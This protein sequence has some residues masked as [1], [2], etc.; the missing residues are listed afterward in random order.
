MSAAFAAAALLALLSNGVP[1]AAITTAPIN[2]VIYDPPRAIDPTTTLL[3]TVAFAAPRDSTPAR[4]LAEW[5]RFVAP[6][7]EEE[8]YL[9]HLQV[10]GL[11][12]RYPW[13]LRGFSGQESRRLAARIGTHPWSGRSTFTRRPRFIAPRPFSIAFW[14]NTAFPYGSNDGPVWAGRGATGSIEAGIHASAGPLSVVVAP[15]AF[16]AQN[17]SFTLLD[18]GLSGNQA[19]ADGQFGTA[20]DRPQRFGDGAY[21]RLDPGNSTL[22]VDVGPLAAG[23]S[24]ANMV[25]GPFDR[26]PFILGTNAPGFAH[27]F[28]GTA[29][30]LPLW[31]ARIHGRVVWGRLEQSAYSPVEGEPTYF[32]VSESGTRRFASGLVA[33]LEPRG[34]SGL[35]LGVARF[36]HSPWPRSGIPSTYFRKPFTGF[37]KRALPGTPGFPDLQGGGDNQLAS[38][39]ARWLIP[40]A[41]LEVYAEYGREDHSFDKRDFLQ[42]PDH[43]RAYGLGVRRVVLARPS[44]LDGVG[45]ELF[46]FQLPHLVR[47]GRGEGGTYTHAILRQGHTSRGQL[48]GADV[49]VG[50]GAGFSVRWDRYVPTGRTSIALHRIVRMERGTFFSSGS[51]DRRATDVQYALHG[52][53][54]RRLGPS[55]LT[56][57]ATLIRELNRNFGDDAWG[58]S[59]NAKARLHLSRY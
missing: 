40:A 11:V 37:L 59:L 28:V 25:W 49:A 58:V 34:L 29:R 56:L 33:I 22:R 39:F 18:N 42:Q 53:R 30:P 26:Y 15:I 19:F 24:T 10:A 12:R 1:A 45:F 3:D 46:N 47:T 23:I 17:S 54:H 6:N 51:I 5:I 20:V 4:D 14:H 13:S 36:F 27:G 50:T 43:S 44:R 52:E 57:G 35:E 2:A 8:H 16:S 41:R 21:A 38:A 7:D 55:D 31:L 32:S 9:R 48:L